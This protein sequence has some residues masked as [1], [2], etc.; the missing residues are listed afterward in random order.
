[1][2]AR[3]PSYGVTMPTWLGL[4]PAER[5]RVTTFSTLAASVRLR[6]DVRRAHLRRVG[7]RRDGRSEG[8]ATLVAAVGGHG[9][10]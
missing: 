9:V 7:D 4:T 5:K 6:Y 8:S 1:M 10:P 2:Y 3:C